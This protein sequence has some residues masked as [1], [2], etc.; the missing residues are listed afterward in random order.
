MTI[1]PLQT[2]LAEHARGAKA[3]FNAAKTLDVVA[4][5]DYPD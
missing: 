2:A 3:G 5:G 1:V 4:P